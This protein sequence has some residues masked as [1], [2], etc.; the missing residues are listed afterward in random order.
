MDAAKIGDF[1]SALRKA[2]GYTQQAVAEK[3]N[4][5]NKTISKWESGGGLPDI[6]VLPA[7]AELYGVTV[8]EILAGQRLDRDPSPTAQARGREAELYLLRRSRLGMNLFCLPAAALAVWEIFV[9]FYQIALLLLYDERWRMGNP[10]MIPLELIAVLLVVVGLLLRRYHLATVK[11]M[12]IG[13]AWQAEWRRSL[14]KALFLVTVL[15]LSLCEYLPLL[16]A[17]GSVIRICVV[18]LLIV[19]WAAV[20]WK[21]PDLLCRCS[22]ILLLLAGVSMCLSCAADA[23]VS[24]RVIPALLTLVPW[25]RY[26][27]YPALLLA[28]ALT[29]TLTQRRPQK[30]I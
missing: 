23:A 29:Q 10:W 19:L 20:L 7:L 6:T 15:S 14:Q 22:K 21:K 12:G 11:I 16:I 18:A 5:S 4:L 17:R 24:R 25:L 27:L 30:T 3:L 1:L 9:Y 8:D 13:A 28:S 2:R 26:L